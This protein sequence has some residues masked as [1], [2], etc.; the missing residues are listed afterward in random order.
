MV[1]LGGMI[2]FLAMNLDWLRVIAA[3]AAWAFL[4]TGLRAQGCGLIR[5]EADNALTA[6]PKNHKVVLENDH[7]RVIDAMIP[8]HTIEPAHTHIWPG[9]LIADQSGPNELPWSKVDIRWSDAGARKANENTKDTATHNLRIDIKNADCQPS[10]NLA[11]PS[12]DAV[13][14]HDPNMTVAFE[15][16]YV[17]VLS[18]RVPPGEKEPWHTHTWP[19]VVVYFRLPPS[20]RLSPDGGKKPRAELTHMEISFD[21]NSQPVH[22]VEN[23]GKVMYQAYRI[24]LKPTTTVALATR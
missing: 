20:Q 11:L 15:N 14:V 23:L 13:A 5:P 17:R 4:P 24:E 1:I 9:V 18:V 19:A 7:V 6:A 21:P 10:K 8:A 2:L 16:Q 12:T 22:S 3:I